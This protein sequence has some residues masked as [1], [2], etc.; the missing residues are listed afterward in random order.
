MSKIKICAAQVE[1]S[2]SF[3]NNIESAK[4]CMK[5]ASKSNCDIICFP[6]IFL[7]GPLNKKAYSHGMV[8]K[9]KKF[10]P[11]LCKEYGLHCI[12]GSIIEKISNNYYNISYLIDDKGHIA[13]H[14]KKIHLV[15]NNEAKH[16]KPGSST[17]VFKTKIGNIGIQICRD[18]LYPEVTRRLMLNN[19]EI[20]FCPSFWCSKSDSYAYIYNHRYFK[21]VKPREVDVLCS[22]RA[23]ESGV[24]FVY[25]NA[26]GTYY[27]NCNDVLLGRSQISLPFYGTTD[28]LAS[29]KKGLIIKN[30][31][32][33]IV[34]DAKLVYKMEK[35]IKRY[36]N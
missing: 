35:D 8:T 22:A 7:T 27:K 31:D 10:F 17:P 29:N 23:I 1:V 18:L 11:T 21:N 4:D 20:I 19:S 15:Q 2:D 3:G 12:M 32:F 30:I 9:S 5:M 36:Y 34:K 14:Y 16:L 26:A 33:G 24:V 25:V 28:I 13:G 6:E